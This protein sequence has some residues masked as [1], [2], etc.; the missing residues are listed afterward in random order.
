MIM[1]KNAKIYNDGN[2]TRLCVSCNARRH[3]NEMIRIALSPDGKVYIDETGRGQGRGCYLCVN[4][5]C[6]SSAMKSGKMARA[7]KSEIPPEIYDALKE[8]AGK[9]NE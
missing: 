7:L 9:I 1:R 3:K 8:K 4:S 2:F 6:I 5:E